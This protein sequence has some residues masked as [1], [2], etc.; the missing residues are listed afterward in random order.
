MRKIIKALPLGVGLPIVIG[1]ASVSPGDAASNV[2][3][4]ASLLGLHD[5][6]AW[7]AGRAADPII[8]LVAFGLAAIYWIAVWGVPRH[9]IHEHAQRLDRLESVTANLPSTKTDGAGVGKN[10]ISEAIRIVF[11]REP[12]FLPE[13]RLADGTVRRAVEVKLRNVGN[14]WL[15][16]CLVEVT[17]ISPEPPQVALYALEP[18]RTL[19]FDMEKNYEIVAF[20]RVKSSIEQP[21]YNTG[22]TIFYSMPGAWGGGCYVILLDNTKYLIRLKASAA[23]SKPHEVDMYIWVDEGRAL[24]AEMAS[25]AT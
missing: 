16:D 20:N 8:I 1:I 17:S 10:T 19:N 23:E 6:P 14:G 15:S 12:E 11:R 9:R 25:P 22:P 7:L 13:R 24:Q 21:I 3:K 5:V 4:W 2:S 18:G